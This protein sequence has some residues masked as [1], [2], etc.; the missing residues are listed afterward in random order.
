MEDVGD[1]LL[2][3]PGQDDGSE[4]IATPDLHAAA[5]D[6]FAD[7]GGGHPGIEHVGLAETHV[8]KVDG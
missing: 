2:E 4:T 5:F 6:V 1:R 3:F 8:G 7:G